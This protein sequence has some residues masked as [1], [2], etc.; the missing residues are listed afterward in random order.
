MDYDD[1][2]F[3]HF[4]LVLRGVHLSVR[5]Y[6]SEYAFTSI[7]SNISLRGCKHA[8][9]GSERFATSKN[10]TLEPPF[11]GRQRDKGTCPLNRGEK[12]KDYMRIL[13]PRTGS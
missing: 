3:V 13:P 2:V 1:R 12:Y 10:I 7:G 6:S 4:A 11:R 9:H 8:A 5:S